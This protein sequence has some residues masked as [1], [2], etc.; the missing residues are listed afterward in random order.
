[1]TSKGEESLSDDF[2]RRIRAARVYGEFPQ[3]EFARKLGISVATLVR[4]EKGQRK[5]PALTR[6]GLAA[7]VEELTGID[8]GFVSRGVKRDV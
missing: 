6:P 5:V 8:E 3:I 7:K 4:Y 1:M 2:G